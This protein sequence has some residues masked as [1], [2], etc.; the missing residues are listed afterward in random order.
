M[1]GL[2]LDTTLDYDLPMK[3]ALAV[4][5]R[6]ARIDTADVESMFFWRPW[7]CIGATF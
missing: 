7:S 4:M 6:E 3:D 1:E 5:H 2:G